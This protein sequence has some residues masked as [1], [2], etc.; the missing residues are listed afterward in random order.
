LKRT[1]SQAL[2]TAVVAGACSLAGLPPAAGALA[3][4]LGASASTASPWSQPGTLGS[5]ASAGAARAVFPRDKPAHATGAG[6]VVWSAARGCA[7][8]AGTVVSAIG[9]SNDVPSAPHY[10]LAPDGRR[11]SSSAPLSVAPAPHGQFV[12]AGSPGPGG[13]DGSD[14][15][16]LVQG[17]AAGAFA[18]LGALAGAARSGTLAT[19]YL[20]DVAALSPIAG[21]LDDD[22]LELRVERYFA[23]ALSPAIAIA[24]RGGAIE[25]PTVGV[26]FRTDAIVAWAQR[27]ALYAR[28]VPAADRP[29]AAIPQPT[30]RL[31]SV[32][33]S[34]RVSALISDDNR[35]IV[36]WAEQRAGQTSV[37]VDVSGAGVRFAK[38]QLLERF[39]DPAGAAYP[40]TSPLLTRLSSESVMLAW[41][42]AQQGHWVVRAAAIDL[43]GL[44]ATSTISSLEGDA[45][46]SDLAP[47]P[48]GEVIALWSEPQRKSDGTLDLG[49]QAIAAARGIDAYPGKATFAAPEQIAP[50]GANE[51][52]TV[53]FDPA[54]DRAIALWRGA[55]G[56]VEY[57]IRS[58]SGR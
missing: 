42:G 47:G 14:G 53:A 57:A 20:G 27:G 43:N 7:S 19:G 44:R 21:G 52:A 17:T 24:G 38:P 5:C 35:A 41:S 58:A 26:D 46:L 50:A 54:S 34:P 11:I 9:A 1:I 33:R 28:D 13:S 48:D 56:V 32:A 36:A 15:G 16:S 12:I 51:A 40:L 22:G 10:A 2:A 49:D 18:P 39:T 55:R 37:Y 8:G 31:A 3:S 6:A 45:L 29:A 23:N 30:Q 4:A 25:A